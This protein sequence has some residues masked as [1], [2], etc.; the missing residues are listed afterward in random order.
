AEERQQ[1][2]FAE[3]VEVDVLDDHHLAIIDG[4]QRLVQHGVDVC[5]IP[6]REESEC[7]LDPLRRLAQAFAAG[8]LAELPQQ[9]PDEFLHPPILYLRHQRA[10]CRFAVRRS[11]ASAERTASRGAVA[12]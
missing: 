12:G 5:V 1:M 10:E 8:I 4:E 11:S 7:F 2:V 6:A 3:T 9:L